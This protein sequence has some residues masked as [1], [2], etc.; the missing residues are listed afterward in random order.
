VTGPALR[1]VHHVQLGLPPGAEDRARAFYADALGM[2]EV[3]KPPALVG[4]GGAWFRSG[5]VELHLG[6][7]PDFRPATKAHPGLLVEGL[8]GWAERLAEC[9]APVRWDDALPGHRRF[10]T[11]DPFGNRLELLEPGG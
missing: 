8:D 5:R 3:P 4:R 10:Y 9:G 7:E 6:V 2:T 1:A 11:A